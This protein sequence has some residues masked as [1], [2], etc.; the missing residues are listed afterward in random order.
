MHLQLHSKDAQLGNV[1]FESHAN[2][3]ENRKFHKSPK[4][5]NS[6][7]QNDDF[8]EI[9]ADSHNAP[10]HSK[11]IQLISDPADQV[12]ALLGF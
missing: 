11:N 12:D 7:Q 6:P 10:N 5:D 3:V 4:N 8:E 1:S 9:P 2:Q